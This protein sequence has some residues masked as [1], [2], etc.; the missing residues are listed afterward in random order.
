MYLFP[1]PAKRLACLFIIL[2]L[3]LILCSS[4]LAAPDADEDSKST[5]LLLMLED[6]IAE[7]GGKVSDMSDEELKSV[8]RDISERAGFDLSESQIESLA[9]TARSAGEGA[10][11][12]SDKVESASGFI[13]TIASLFNAAKGI[14]ASVFEFISRAIEWVGELIESF[15]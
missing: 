3:S 7:L 8:I 12:I 10:E 4:A 2:C 5:E 9:E 11:N 13:K 1:A 14:I 6:E 15:S